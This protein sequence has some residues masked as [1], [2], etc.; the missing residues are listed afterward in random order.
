MPDL[1]IITGSNGAGKS[2]VGPTY[3]PDYI[4]NNYTVFDGDKLFVQKQRELWK[5]GIRAHKEAKKLAFS[6]VEETFDNLV[7][8]TI[9][10][11]DNFAYEGHFTNDA[12]WDI[13]RRFKEHGYSIHLIFLGLKSPDLS[14]LRVIDRSKEGGHYVDPFTIRDNFYGNLEKLDKYYATIDHLK[15]ID[16][17]STIHL[18]VVQIDA[19]T[20]THIL[21][22]NELPSWFSD[23]LK[24]LSDWVLTQGYNK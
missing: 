14:E 6:F 20:I 22:F 4:K 18:L 17:S 8:N 15:I 13:P 12:T 24:R 23:N 19:G 16:T 2:S 9:S 21:P 1:F 11:N 3:L 10:T 5:Q 7:E